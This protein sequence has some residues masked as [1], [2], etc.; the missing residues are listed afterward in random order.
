MSGFGWN[1]YAFFAA[2]AAWVIGYNVWAW[3]VD[4]SGRDERR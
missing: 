4:R 3:W 1:F 2:A